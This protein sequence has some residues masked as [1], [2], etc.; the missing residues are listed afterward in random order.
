MNFY[1]SLFKV[2]VFLKIVRAIDFNVI[3]VIMDLRGDHLAGTHITIMFT[4]NIN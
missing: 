3:G 1:Q 2:V 4:L